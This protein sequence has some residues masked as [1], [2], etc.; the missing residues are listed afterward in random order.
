MHITRAA[1][2]FDWIMG[3]SKALVVLGAQW[4]DEGKVLAS[5]LVFIEKG[6]ACQRTRRA[7]RKNF[8]H[9]CATHLRVD[10]TEFWQA[11]RET[12]PNNFIH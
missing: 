5:N 10:T 6:K 3:P 4:G 12:W 1:R 8:Y 11:R 9:A 2:V 7:C